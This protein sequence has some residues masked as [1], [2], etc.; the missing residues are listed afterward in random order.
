MGSLVQSDDNKLLRL[1]LDDLDSY[2]VKPENI[3]KSTSI[4]NLPQAKQ[5]KLLN[6]LIN[7]DLLDE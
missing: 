5:D 1:L 3:F 2:D 6:L 7:M 4:K